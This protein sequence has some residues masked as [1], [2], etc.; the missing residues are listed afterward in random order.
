[1]N[2][3]LGA[4]SDAVFFAPTV[5]GSR[6]HCRKLLSFQTSR[7]AGRHTESAAGA[8]I[9]YNYGE[10]LIHRS[11]LHNF[12]LALPPRGPRLVTIITIIKKTR[13]DFSHQGEPPRRI[14]AEV[15]GRN[16]A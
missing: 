15:S 7:A 11:F 3:I 16:N 6:E 12:L 9:F 14:T 5:F 4:G 2:G 13:N 1:M 8:G 10:P